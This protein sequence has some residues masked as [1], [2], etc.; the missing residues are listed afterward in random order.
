MKKLTSLMLGSGLAFALPT[1]APAVT[2]EGHFSGYADHAGVGGVYAPGM[3]Y[4]AYL[5]LNSVQTNP[6]YPWDPTKEYTAVINAVVASYTGGFTQSVDFQNGA[7]FRIFEDTSTA[8]DFANPATFTDGTLILSGGSNDMFGQRVDVFGLPWNFYGTIVFVSGAGLGD[9]AAQCAFGLIMNDFV[10]FQIGTFPPGYEE[11][12]DAEWKCP[13]T[14]PV[15]AASWGD[16][17]ALY[18]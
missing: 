13:D 14:T 5:T 16:V 6:W 9:L 10:N 4:T 2:L 7:Q 3:V 15:D 8:A 17:K 1:L 11:A 18:R 12:Y